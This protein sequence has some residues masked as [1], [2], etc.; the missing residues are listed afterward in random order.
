LKPAI[1]AGEG[2]N[3]RLTL[4]TATTKQLHSSHGLPV[5]GRMTNQSRFQQGDFLASAGDTAC[6]L[7]INICGEKTKV[8]YGR[9][10]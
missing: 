4:S 2:F 8:S 1:G 9:Q 3:Q 5:R 6:F 7:H 10:N